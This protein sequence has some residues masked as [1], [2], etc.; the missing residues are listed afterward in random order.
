MVNSNTKKIALV[1]GNAQGL[2]KELSDWLGAHGY[3]Q[4]LLVR[5]ADYD[6][7][8]PEAAARLFD[9]VLAQYG[10]LDLL[11][12]NLGNYVAKYIDEI[13]LAEWHEMMDTNLNSAFYLSQ[14]ALPH[15]RASRGQIV[16][17][18][19]A[20]LGKFSPYPNV[21]AYQAAK[22]G[23]LVLTKGMAKAEAEYGVRVNMVSP[24]SMVNTIKHNAVDKIPMGRLA[25]FD[26]VILAIEFVLENNYVTGQ[27]LEVAG[28]WDL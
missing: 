6:L 20:G 10:R 2:G 1:T 11:V 19:F 18:G 23:L 24:G 22:A 26:E 25:E 13:S 8:K 7:R 4:P 21:I 3:E 5:S 14:L 12:N 9:T 16:N 17:I 28:G 15:L 27:N